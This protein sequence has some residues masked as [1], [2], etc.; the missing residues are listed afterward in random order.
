MI[1][2]SLPA[3]FQPS[4]E[5]RRMAANH[6]IR[7]KWVEFANAIFAGTGIRPSDVQY[8]EMRR[9]FYGGWHSALT[10]FREVLGHPELSEDDGVWVAEQWEAEGHEFASAM[11]RGKA[12]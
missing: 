11:L 6:A 1:P 7:E 8:V 4:D 10:T 12:R 5:A 2:T 3:D 9:A